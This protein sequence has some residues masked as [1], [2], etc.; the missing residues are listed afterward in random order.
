M[1]DLRAISKHWAIEP[2][3]LHNLTANFE[4]TQAGLSLFSERPLAKTRTAT[5]RGGVAVIPVHGVITPRL[6]LFTILFGGTALDCLARDIQ[7]A[8]DD[9]EVHAIL[10]DIDSPG[11]VAVG[12]A[13]MAEIINHAK[14][15][16][17]VWSYAGRNCCS[18]AYW[19]AAATDKILCHKS[20]LLGSIGVV[21]TIPV[22]ET[23]DADGY[24]MIEVIST[25]AKNKRPDPRTPEGLDTIRAELDALETEFIKSVAAY[26]KLPEDTIKSDFGQGGVLIGNKAVTVGMADA[27]ATYEGALAQLST[28]ITPQKGEPKMEKKEEL[29]I[30]PEQVAAYREEGAKAERERL[31]ALD[32]VA[33][34]GHEDLLAKAKADPAMTAEKLAL[35][36]VKSEK[37]KGNKHL[38]SLKA[39]ET[40]MPVIE[41]S[42]PAATEAVGATPEER[43]ENEWNAKAEIR[44]EFGGDKAAYIAFAVAQENGQI[45]IQKKGE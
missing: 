4:K 17:P 6:D 13:E 41:P 37:A 27:L 8:L 33:I 29:A 10:L 3:A 1:N 16:K 14:G 42:V 2:D 34:V 44:K 39:A 43:A 20:A 12:P 40:A 26:R 7:T 21:S 38:E 28:L 5:I 25:N 22:Q 32:E 11:G 15:I 19:L 31:L 24:K 35:E 23:A 30:T 9:T 18:A 36:I 45:K